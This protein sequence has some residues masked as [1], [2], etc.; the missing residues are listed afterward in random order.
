MRWALLISGLLACA[1]TASFAQSFD[2]SGDVSAGV[3]YDSD[4]A[5]GNFDAYNDF[6]F[7]VSAAGQSDSALDFGALL[8]FDETG[9]DDSEVFLTGDFGTITVGQ[10]D[11]ASDGFG[12]S[13]IGF[14]G[15]GVDDVAEQFKNATAGA[16]VLYSYSSGGVSI[17]ASA[18]VGTEQSYGLAAE[19]QT[20]GLSLGLGF[21]DDTDAGNSTV[22]VTAGYS[23]G[24]LAVTGL[25]SDW[26]EG[27]QGYGLDLSLDTGGA[28]FTA[29]WAQAN[30]TAADPDDGVGDAYG[31]GVSVPL[32]GGLTVSGGLGVIETDAVTDGSRTVADIGVT[33]NF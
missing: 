3:T 19:Y 15:L 27:S 21:V 11:P 14:S 29:A 5:A 22:S 2:L 12:I 4:A 8:D 23:F 6:T 1:G 17:V 28:T 26:S 18:E 9:V 30:G 16:D 32:G 10:V 20:G 33:M 24:A 25:Y 7:S 31:L 13:D